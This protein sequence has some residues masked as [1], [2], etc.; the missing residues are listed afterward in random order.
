MF[1]LLRGDRC[2]WFLYHCAGLCLCVCVFF[3][4][5]TVKIVCNLLCL[6]CHIQSWRSFS[7]LPPWR[8]FHNNKYTPTISFS[9]VA[10]CLY[11]WCSM[12]VYIHG[13]WQL[14]IFNFVLLLVIMLYSF[15]AIYLYLRLFAKCTCAFW[16]ELIFRFTILQKHGFD[17]FPSYLS[18]VGEGIGLAVEMRNW[19]RPSEETAL[20]HKTLRW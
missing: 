5:N 12:N 17:F 6:D 18:G 14:V 4:T 8:S 9:G 1:P 10:E 19:T 16:D 7:S 11:W 2:S 15:L 3:L 20:L 13:T